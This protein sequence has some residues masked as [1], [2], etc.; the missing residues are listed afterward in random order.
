MLDTVSLA[1]PMEILLRPSTP[2]LHDR[3]NIISEILLGRTQI[4]PRTDHIIHGGMY[5]RT[6]N[7]PANVDMMGSLILKATVLIVCG[8]C[9]MLAGDERVEL[10]GYNV[11][12][13][14]AGRKQL[15][16]TRSPVVMTMI[17]PT[18]AR[19]VK[20]AEN[21]VFAEADLLQ[22]RQDASGDTVIITGE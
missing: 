2:E 11:L 12:P 21:E 22:S 5:I 14:C 9:S 10:N 8:S 4:Q 15:F 17:F 18:S 20:E 6:L 7:L 13:G 19:T 3:L 1:I 16:T